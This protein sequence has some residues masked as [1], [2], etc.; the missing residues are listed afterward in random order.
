MFTASTIE[1]LQGAPVRFPRFPGR[2]YNI[3]SDYLIFNAPRPLPGEITWEGDFLSGRYYAAMPADDHR[4]VTALKLDACIV[5]HLPDADAQR[6][7]A[8][9]LMARNHPGDFGW[10]TRQRIA[11]MTHKQIQKL[12][13]VQSRGM[14]WRD[15]QS[16]NL[17]W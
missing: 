17:S 2:P 7:L 13:D 8:R 4:V 14:Q 10:E 1:S 5:E 6:E 11:E 3:P 16:L 9:E 12:I 15:F